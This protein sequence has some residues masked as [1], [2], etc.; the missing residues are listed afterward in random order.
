MAELFDDIARILAAPVSRRRSFRLVGGVVA[1]ALVSAFRVE[2]LSAQQG[3]PDSGPPPSGSGA[4]TPE[5]LTSEDFYDC[6][7]KKGITCC[8]VDTCCAG[9]GGAGAVCCDPKIAG[10]QCVCPNGTCAASSGA[11]CPPPCYLCTAAVFTG[12]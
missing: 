12:P 2:P 9:T 4:C 10:Q 5:Q 7:K 6:G 3:P 8:R 11:T 1:A